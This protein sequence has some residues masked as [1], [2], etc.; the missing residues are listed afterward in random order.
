MPSFDIVSKVQW[1]EVENAVNQAEKEVSQRFDFKDTG[2]ELEKTGNDIVV[3]SSTEERAKAALS[4]VQ[5]KLVKRKVS[6]KFF[7]VGKPE[8]TAKGGAKITLKVKEGIESEKAK[9]I[10]QS[11]K[12][13]KLKVQAAIQGD[14]LRVTGKSKDELQTAIQH[15]KAQDF[16]LELQ[17]VNFRD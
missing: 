15:L 7:D 14:Q 8:P 10:V 1:H 3:R 2:T 13:A 17:Y 4:V 6:P 5:E 12:D 9:A 11:V 16:G